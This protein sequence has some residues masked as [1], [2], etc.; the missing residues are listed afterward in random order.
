MASLTLCLLFLLV[1][2]SL[3]L[4]HHQ[5]LHGLCIESE[6]AALLNFIQGFNPSARFASW[7]VDEDC[8]KWKGVACNNRTGHIHA[9]DLRSQNP[10]D[11]LQGTIPRCVDNFLTMARIEAVPSYVYDPDTAYR[12]DLLQTLIKRDNIRIIVFLIDLSTNQLSGEI[13]V[14]LTRLVRLIGLNLSHNNLIGPI[15]SAIGALKDLDF[16]DLSRNKLSCSIPPEMANLTMAV[17]NLS[18]NNLSGKIPL[19]PPFLELDASSFMKNEKLCGHPLKK[20]CSEPFYEDPQC[21]V[22]IQQDMEREDKDHDELP[23]FYIS[24]GIGFI[25]AIWVYWTVLLLNESWREVF[26]K[27]VD[28]VVERILIMATVSGARS[29]TKLEKLVPR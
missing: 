26:L 19:G 3:S 6:K 12:K 7:R 2:F 24:L 23:S 28:K 16:L 9:L 13:P 15:P 20:A 8:C 29:R 4:D 17:L 27:F 14:E 11:F 5:N 10:I 21:K 1:G 18:Y 22:K 25:T